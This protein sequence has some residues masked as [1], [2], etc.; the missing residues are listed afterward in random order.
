MKSLGILNES[1]NGLPRAVVRLVLGRLP[2]VLVKDESERWFV[3]KVK[4]FFPLLFSQTQNTDI[5]LASFA[6]I[7]EDLR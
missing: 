2:G 4:R 5:K 6:L 3:D 7:Q 1:R